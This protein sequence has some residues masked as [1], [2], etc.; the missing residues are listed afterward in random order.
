MDDPVRIVETVGTPT[1]VVA[2]TTSW[3]EFPR[4]WGPLLAEVWA[5]CA[6]RI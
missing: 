3:D 1:A 4:L 6:G 2:E 5:S